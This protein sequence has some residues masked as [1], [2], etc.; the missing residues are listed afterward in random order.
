MREFFATWGEPVWFTHESQDENAWLALVTSKGNLWD[1]QAALVP[2]R[3]AHRF[4]V[5]PEGYF[6]ADVPEGIGLV[7][8]ERWTILPWNEGAL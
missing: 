3:L 8:S 4:D 1:F 5:V 7:E 6:R 2:A